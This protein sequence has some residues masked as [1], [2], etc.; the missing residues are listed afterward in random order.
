MNKREA[1][2]IA[3]E[4]VIIA[5]EAHKLGINASHSLLIIANMPKVKHMIDQQAKGK[6]REIMIAL[7]MDIHPFQPQKSNGQT[8]E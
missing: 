8:K 6:N 4:V 1:E 2:I 7:G 5:R 3:D